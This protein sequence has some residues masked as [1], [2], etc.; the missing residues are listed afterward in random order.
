[1]KKFYLILCA[2]FMVLSLSSIAGAY[3]IESLNWWTY[4]DF[5]GPDLN[6][7]L[8]SVHTDISGT[9]TVNDGLEIST[10]SPDNTYFGMHAIGANFIFNSGQFFAAKVPFN[11]I[12]AFVPEAGSQVVSL[13][14]DMNQYPDVSLDFNLN[15]GLTYDFLGYTGMYFIAGYPDGF[16]GTPTQATQGSFGLIYDGTNLS[17]YFNDGNGWQ[18]LYTGT[19]LWS[20]QVNFYLSA[21]VQNEGS[22]QVTIDNVQF[23]SVPIPSTF[24]LLGP[25]LIGLAGFRRKFRRK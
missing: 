22:L 20:G 23:G 18:P 14:I 3:T 19:P 5:P 21:E 4:D 24:F 7:T 11:I 1:M 25:G 8:W 16:I 9:Y 10:S 13:G 15:W 6:T 2:V 12:T 17:M